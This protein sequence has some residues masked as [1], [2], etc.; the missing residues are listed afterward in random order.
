MDYDYLSKLSVK[1]LKFLI[2]FNEWYYNGNPAHTMHKLSKERKKCY[3]RNDAQRRDVM[4]HELTIYLDMSI[5]TY[6]NYDTD[7]IINSDEDSYHDKEKSTIYQK[8]NWGREC[9]ECAPCY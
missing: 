2:K 3:R 4:N 5:C 8:S 7:Y 6:N 1:E 9:T